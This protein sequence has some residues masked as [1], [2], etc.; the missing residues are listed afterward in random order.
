QVEVAIRA[1][2]VENQM[3]TNATNT[4]GKGASS[5]NDGSFQDSS[6][7]LQHALP[8]FVS[9]GNGPE[10]VVATG[11]GRGAAAG[12]VSGVGSEVSLG[13]GEGGEGGGAEVER[14][15]DCGRTFAPGR[16]RSHAKACRSVFLERRRPYDPKAMRARGTPLEFFQQPTRA[17]S[18]D[19]NPCTSGKGGDGGGDAAS[20]RGVGRNK[21]SPVG[22][23]SAR[24]EGSSQGGD[25]D[26]V[27]LGRL[28]V[29]V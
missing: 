1:V 12:E 28:D 23:S 17:A 8:P 6:T 16:L 14:C 3:H 25:A 20:R 5:L 22:G 19:D 24:R 4:H 13:G 2:S 9:K 11:G 18:S 29:S 26:R 7:L 15:E 27:S 10:N 21:P